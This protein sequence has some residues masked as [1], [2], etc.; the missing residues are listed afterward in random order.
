MKFVEIDDDRRQNIA[1]AKSGAEWMSLLTNSLRG[2]MR[3]SGFDI[4]RYPPLHSNLGRMKRILDFHHINLVID[5]G[6]NEGQFGHALRVLGYLGSIVSFEPLNR[7]HRELER[8]CSH[9][10][11]WIAAP[12]MA[13][14]RISGEVSMNVAE[15]L[16][17]SSVL[18]MSSLHREAAPASKYRSTETVPI[19]VLDDVA[20]QYFTGTSLAL[21]KIDTQGFEAEVLAGANELLS[22]TECVQLEM[23]LAELYEG[24]AT[25]L[26]LIQV[27]SG[28]DFTLIDLIPGFTDPRSGHLLQADGLFAKK[29]A[30]ETM[31][32]IRT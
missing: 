17:S 14:G 6:A 5:V 12:R 9:D 31:S 20:L 26:D 18:P 22:R 3:W 11:T 28:K 27:M 15:N 13:L 19:H 4:T 16:E 7:A 8:V 2:A 30:P 1:G 23:S 21:L 29:R 25:Y 10:S 24:Q 32:G